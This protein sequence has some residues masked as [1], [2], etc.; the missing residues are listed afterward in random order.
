VR[1]ARIE[2]A[3]RREPNGAAKT[4]LRIAERNPKLLLEAAGL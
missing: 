4:L 3:D 1:V 2:T